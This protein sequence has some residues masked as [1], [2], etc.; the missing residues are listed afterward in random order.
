MAILEYNAITKG[1]YIEFEGEPYEILD[2]HVF[3]KQMRK[4]VNQVKMRHLIS[5]KV[6]E[7]SFH[8]AE[9]SEEAEIDSRK[10]KYLYAN[11]GEFWF[12]EEN[13]PAKRFSLK[14][15]LVGPQGP[16][17][18]PNSIVEIL[19]F[20][21]RL[22]GVKMPIKVELKVKTAPPGIKGDTR[23][24]GNKQIILETGAA[25]NA[26]LFINEGDTIIV[27]TETGEYVSRA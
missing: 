10:V 4:P 17:L 27:N 16:Y 23:Q 6:T 1:K 12:C 7:Y 24:G 19:T 5:G 26:P 21:D 18:K 22:V 20:H 2:S 13:E 8:A 3:R 15:E 9:K 14:E 25:I 11:K